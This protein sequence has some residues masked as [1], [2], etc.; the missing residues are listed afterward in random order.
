MEM[1]RRNTFFVVTTLFRHL[2]KFHISCVASCTRPSKKSDFVTPHH[3]TSSYIEYKYG[4]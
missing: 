4:R 3:E 1:C 2:P